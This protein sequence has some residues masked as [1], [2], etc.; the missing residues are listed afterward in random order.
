VAIFGNSARLS[1]MTH[2][3]KSW[4]TENEVVDA[5]AEHLQKTG[6]EKIRT[7]N[8]M[9]QGIDI[10]AERSGV[11]VA[12]E[13]KGGGSSKPG[14]AK[15]GKPFDNGQKCKPSCGRGSNRAA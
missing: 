3:L 14:T 7:C 2:E 11:T 13:A 9:Q 10:Y 4:L 5:V 6:W 15:Y 8:T 1:D 12:I